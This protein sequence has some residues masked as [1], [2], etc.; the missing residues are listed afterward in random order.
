MK[1]RGK[2]QDLLQ[3]QIHHTVPTHLHRLLLVG[4][5]VQMK[6]EIF[7]ITTMIVVNPLG[8]NQLVMLPP[9]ITHL[10]QH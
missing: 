1:L 5:S 2:N 9:P 3:Q 6:M 7:I 8:R 10:H 4:K